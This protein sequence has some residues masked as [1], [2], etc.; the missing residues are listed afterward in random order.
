MIGF[1]RRD[2]SARNAPSSASAPPP[3]P[4]VRAESRPYSL[5][6]TIANAPSI[7]ASVISTEPSQSTP[8]PRPMP[9]FSSISAEPSTNAT[10]PIGT[11]TKKIQCQS[12][13]CVSAPPASRPIEPPPADD[14]RVQAHRLGLLASLGE[15]GDDDRED[16]AR[17]DR[18]ADALEQ[19]RADQQPLAVG[20]P[21]QDGGGGEQHEPAQEH[22]LAPDE[23][24]EPPGQQ[25][26][27]AEG[28]QVAVRCTQ[29]RL[30]W[31][32]CRS[33]WIEGSATFT[34]VASSTII[35][36]PR[37]STASAIQRRRSLRCDLGR[38]ASARVRVAASPAATSRPRVGA[39]RSAAP[40]RRLRRAATPAAAGFLFSSC[41]MI[42][43][44]GSFVAIWDTIARIIPIQ[45][46]SMK[47]LKSLL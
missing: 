13:D 40:A 30:P 31:E 43:P 37:Q 27:A 9:S 20:D 22:A 24:A 45:G 41:S 1:A 36:W 38:G 34:I 44:C 29:V 46:R 4:S 6:L 17:G 47:N 25:Q 21:A 8:P 33:C 32:K 42:V 14:E 12:S 23:V 18:A 26:E 3:T 11:L 15:L 28:D 35:S 5:D 16:H 39:S 10:M 7:V 19:A 2:S